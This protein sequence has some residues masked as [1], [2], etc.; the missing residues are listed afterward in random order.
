MDRID[1]I[2]KWSFNAAFEKDLS[3]DK[4]LHFHEDGTG[5]I[6]GGFEVVLNYDWEISEDGNDVLI[7]NN[8]LPDGKPCGKRELMES[9]ATLIEETLPMGEFQVINFSKFSL[10]FGLRKFAKIKT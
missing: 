8:S 2:G 7:G 3:N 4:Q 6:V 1:I 10:P 9:G 5:N